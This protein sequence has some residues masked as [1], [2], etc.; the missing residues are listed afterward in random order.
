MVSHVTKCLPL[1][2]GRRI[3]VTRLDACGRPIYGDDS[4]V[5]SKGFVRVGYTANTTETEEINLPNA[6]GERCVYE[7]AVTSLVGYGIEIEFCNVDPELLSILTGQSVVLAADGSTV[8]GFDIDT[9]VALDSSN[10]ALELWAGSPTGDA[11][12]T[13]GAQGSFGYVLL[14]FVSG[15]ILG[16]FEVANAAVSF[17]V[18]GANTKEGNAWGVGPYKDIMLN[19]ST[20]I[21]EVQ[22]ATITG[23]PTGGTFTLTFNGQTTAAIAYNAAAAVVQTALE[24]LSNIGVGEAVVTG[25]PGPGTPYTVTFGG[26]FAGTDVPQMTAT[27]S[28]T[29]GT[30]PA[31]AITTITPGVAPKPGAMATPVSTTAALRT[32]LVDLAPPV[33]AC[34][35][36]PLLDPGLAPLTAVAGTENLVD[37]TG[38]TAD[39]AVTPVSSG[40]VYYDFGDGGWDYVSA[41]GTTSH[42]YTAA[43]AYTVKAS[44][45]GVWVTTTV[46]IPFP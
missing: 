25:G 43:G 10:F 21:N 14:P 37:T 3:R 9:K 29:G 36:R 28:F 19:P 17:T 2:K 44:Q 23:T 11:C 8:I 35:A 42:K 27:G 6:S 22:R 18:T 13:A 39:F 1:A 31:I 45:N 15:G 46:T 5:V 7:A 41:P 34:G 40:P 24:N 12:T 4:Q 33:D 32:I 16:D 26:T 38:Y 30:A 20:G